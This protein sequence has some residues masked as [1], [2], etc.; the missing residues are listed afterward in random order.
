MLQGLV[1]MLADLVKRH[2]KYGVR[3][4][5]LKKLNPKLKGKIQPGQKLRVK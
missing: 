3:V 1:P 4:S 2:I 5:A